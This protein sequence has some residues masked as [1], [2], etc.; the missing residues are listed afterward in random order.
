MYIQNNWGQS[1][2][3]LQRGMSVNMLRQ[4]V[5]ANNIANAD[6][7]NFKRSVVNYESALS[8]ALQSDTTR[9]DFQPYY[10]H[11]R[12]IAFDRKVDYQDVRPRRVLD[13]LTTSKNNGNNVDIEE[14]S[15]NY[16]AAQL[17][18]NL[19]VNSVNHHFNSMNIV[20]RG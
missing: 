7:P 1:L 9:D 5:I 11:E 14:E 18:Y 10:T 8:Q 19:M 13:Y 17:A 6:T 20:L 12:H 2:D 3:V 15:S 16:I 4:E